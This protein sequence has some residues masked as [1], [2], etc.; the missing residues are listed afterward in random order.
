MSI[1]LVRIKQDFLMNGEEAE[2][3]IDVNVLCWLLV[4]CP[5]YTERTVNE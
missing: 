3:Q 2:R 1:V 5:M 4:T